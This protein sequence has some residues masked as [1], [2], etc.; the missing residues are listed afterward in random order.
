MTMRVT[1]RESELLQLD[2]CGEGMSLYDDVFA[3]QGGVHVVVRLRSGKRVVRLRLDRIA[4]RMDV[5]GQ[6][7]L[8][9]DC[10]HVGWLRDVGMIPA[11]SAPDANLSSANLY[12][13]N[14]QGANL[15]DA[16]LSSANLYGANL[17]SADLY[18]ANLTRANLTDANLSGARRSSTDAPVAGYAL[19]TVLE[20]A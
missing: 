19:A 20:S 5:L 16:N 6:L 7:W 11:V 14:L 18:C 17:S 2:A 8:A 12:G 3:L 1:I 10:D 13:A 4:L 9:R 15:S